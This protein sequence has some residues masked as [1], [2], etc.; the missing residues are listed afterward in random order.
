M[1]AQPSEYSITADI[2]LAVVFG[3]YGAHCLAYSVTGPMQLTKTWLFSTSALPAARVITP[4]AVQCARM[5]SENED[6]AKPFLSCVHICNR[7]SKYV[8]SARN[9]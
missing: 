6:A 1:C 8:N 5:Q 7:D 2:D 4:A 3:T 9:T